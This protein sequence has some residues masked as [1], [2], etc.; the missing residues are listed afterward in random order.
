MQLSAH[1]E[2]KDMT[3]TWHRMVHASGGGQHMPGT[4][5]GPATSTTPDPELFNVLSLQLSAGVRLPS[6]ISAFGESSMD[7]RTDEERFVPHDL[8]VSESDPPGGQLS[9]SKV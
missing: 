8:L 3:R 6:H 5:Y 7:G 2:I 4:P 1:S 9:S